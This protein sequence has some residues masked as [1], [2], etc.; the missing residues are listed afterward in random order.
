MIM[1]ILSEFQL[2]GERV[3]DLSKEDVGNHLPLFKAFNIISS[4]IHLYES[5]HQLCISEI[6]TER[7][8]MHDK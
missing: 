3:G 4:G 7:S 8:Y 2:N 1:S 5:H 6:K